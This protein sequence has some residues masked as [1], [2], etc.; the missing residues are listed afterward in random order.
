MAGTQNG[1]KFV[2]KMIKISAVVPIYCEEKTLK[3]VV[4]ALLA[5]PLIDEV[6]CIDDASEDASLK[7][8]R[9]FSSRIVLVIHKKNKGK[10]AA[11]VSGIK[12]AKGEIIA[13][14]DGDLLNLNNKHIGTLL[15][16]IIKGKTRVVL[17]SWEVRLKSL[18][19]W[20]GV[21][22]Y[23]RKDLFPHLKKMGDTRFG[24]EMYLNHH[25]KKRQIVSLKGLKGT[26]KN[27]KFS[28]QKLV[29]E[30]IKEGFEVAR[31]KSLLYGTSFTKEV[32]DLFK[33][34]T[35]EEFRAR[36][37]KITDRELKRFIEQY[38]LK[39]IR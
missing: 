1:S 25:F 29:R 38:I 37:S 11:L 12:K 18:A 39:Y 16:P 14:F 28:S 24:V 6:I 31:T 5:S 13:F 34:K 8:L 20:T 4:E 32:N 2:N 10:G 19:T 7:I 9:T 27:G 23:Y 36:L 21:R 15:T 17:G 33:A 22:A 26:R 35:L 30:Y 3:K